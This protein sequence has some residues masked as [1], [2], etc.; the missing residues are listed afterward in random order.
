MKVFVYGTLLKGMEREAMLADSEF[1][2]SATITANLFDLGWYPGVTEGNSTVFGELYRIDQET[3]D[4]LDMIEGYNENGLK[5][6]LFVRKTA[7]VHC[8]PDKR[9]T[10]AF[11]YFFNQPM[12]GECIADGDYREYLSKNDTNL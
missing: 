3:L 10:S 9:T 7:E 6:S 2:G 8:L 12:T 5:N 1:L 11:C 4:Y